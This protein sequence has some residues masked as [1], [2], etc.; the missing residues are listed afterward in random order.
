MADIGVFLE[1]F[2][3]GPNRICRRNGRNQI[4]SVSCMGT[5]YKKLEIKGEPYNGKEKSC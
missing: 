5:T 3:E 1:D 2:G 4:V